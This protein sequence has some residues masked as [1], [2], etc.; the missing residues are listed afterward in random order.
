MSCRSKV[1]LNVLLFF[2]LSVSFAFDGFGQQSYPFPGDYNYLLNKPPN[3]PLLF[4]PDR[5]IGL[6]YTS[7]IS[8][9]NGGYVTSF[10]L[11][12]GATLDSEYAGFGALDFEVVQLTDGMRVVALTSRGGPRTVTI[13]DLSPTGTL[14]FR[15]ERQLTTSG[16]DEG[17]N[18]VLS[19]KAR[20]GFVRV[21]GI[22]SLSEVVAFS[23]DTGE[24][25]NR[26]ALP[27]SDYLNVY[28]SASRALLVTGRNVTLRFY[29][30][31]N[32]A[33]FTSLGD[34]VIPPIGAGSEFQDIYTVFSQDGS[35]VFAGGQATKLSAVDTNT[36]QV[37][38][39]LA[40]NY[41]SNNLK[42]FESGAT[43]LV[44]IR[45]AN[46]D[47]S[48][49]GI[50]V[51]DASNPANMNVVNR[52]SLGSQNFFN[53]RTFAFSRTGKSLIVASDTGVLTYRLPEM[54]ETLN[55]SLF[56]SFGFT[57]ATALDPERIFGAWGSNNNFSAVVYSIPFK[58]NTVANF[59]R[60]GRTDLAVFRPSTS[61]WHWLRSLDNAAG[62][63]PSFGLPTDVPVPGDYDSDEITDLAVF[64]PDSGQWQILRSS[65]NTVQTVDFGIGSDVP[66]VADF[67]GDGKSDIALFRKYVNRWLVIRSGD[68]QIVT[69]RAPFGRVKPV[70]GD[71]DGDGKGDFAAYQNGSWTIQ[72]S[73]GTTLIPTLGS[74]SDIPVS[75]D[76]DF[77]GKTDVAVYSP[78][79][80]TWKIQQSLSG[81]RQVVFGETGDIIVP[82]DYDGDGKT[83]IATYRPSNATF[84]IQRSS[85]PGP[86]T[87]Q[88]GLAGDIPIAAQR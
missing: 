43:R 21:A 58:P 86:A 68:G 82:A 87:V 72:L 73:G 10:D 26:A 75:G 17:S 47:E 29:D 56:T 36:R 54:I 53:R 57:V 5:R 83:D 50:T 80:R 18:L 35:V 74:A 46:S 33:Q 41:S 85:L 64:R 24:I 71:F 70:N 81:F 7:V 67:D 23:L 39:T 30:V 42:I 20:A 60:D 19:G 69:R 2:I 66:T 34:A 1:F 52:L 88:F 27:R 76:F 48:F 59:D 32:P 79:T 8:P 63:T 12:T 37:L 31:T 62:S 6:T 11:A 49:L 15:A 51:V 28:D 16:S 13:Y 9:L 25:L 40:A 77:D 14:T 61:T 3:D 78:S 38:G 65:S 55:A 44:G 4:T 45:G 84:N 22:Q